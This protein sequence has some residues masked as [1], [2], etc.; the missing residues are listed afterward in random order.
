MNSAGVISFSEGDGLIHTPR[1][2]ASKVL[3]VTIGVVLAAVPV[4]RRDNSV[5][6]HLCS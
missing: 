3:L 4:R 1:V 2:D 6:T 5:T